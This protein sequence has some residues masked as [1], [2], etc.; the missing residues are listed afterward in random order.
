M[1]KY[2]DRKITKLIGG[3]IKKLRERAGLEIEDIA[4][5][6]GFHRN[7]IISIER[8][9]N[10]DLSHFVQIAFALGKQPGELLGMDFDIKQR[11]QLS[12]TRK[13][14][15]RLTSRITALIKEDF[16]KTPKSS[17]DV[18]GELAE[19]YPDSVNLETKNISVIL[20]RKVVNGK[21]KAKKSRRSNLYQATRKNK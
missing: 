6:T 16:F 9:S 3:K 5:I 8:G 12:A 15:N 4:E 14:K 19:K 18:Q 2:H 10:T 21:L 20:K 13:Q 1:T 11:N 17:K 7:T